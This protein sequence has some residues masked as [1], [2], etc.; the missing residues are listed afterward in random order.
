MKVTFESANLAETEVVVRGDITSSDVAQ[1]LEYLKSMSSSA[2]KKLLLYKEDEQ[3]LIDP[4]DVVYIEVTESKVQVA[5][6]TERFD[7]KKKLYELKDTLN[8]ANFVQ[9][10]KGTLVNIDFV[11]SVQAEFSGNYT[12]RLKNSKEILT[13]SRKYFKEFKSKI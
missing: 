6:E 4:V 8:N 1:V 7:C 10:N 11:K 12:L 5:T 13:I 9:I 2:A 3:F